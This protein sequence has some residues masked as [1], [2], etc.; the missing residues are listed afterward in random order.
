MNKKI[1]EILKD[2]IRNPLYWGGINKKECIVC[3]ASYNL[4]AECCS[5]G[6]KKFQEYFCAD[7]REVAKAL[8]KAYELG[9]HSKAIKQK[10]DKA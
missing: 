2:D 5:C 1:K 10:T 8:Q 6:S 3:G 4:F 7:I 9:S